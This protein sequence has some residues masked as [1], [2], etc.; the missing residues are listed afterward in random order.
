MTIVVGTF[1]VI[2][3]TIKPV[4]ITF[5]GVW[6]ILSLIR[7]DKRKQIG[8]INSLEKEW[9]D[10]SYKVKLKKAI[11]DLKEEPYLQ[12]MEQ[13]IPANFFNSRD[14]A[15]IWGLVN[16]FRADDFKEAANLLRTIQHQERMEKLQA[17]IIHSTR[18]IN[19]ELKNMR[20]E[21]Q[22]VNVHLKKQEQYLS[23]IASRPAYRT[24]IIMM[25]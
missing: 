24:A 5:F 21:L 25:R 8:K 4:V 9:Q 2:F 10:H 15:G 23:K 16:D 13:V 22:E 1:Y 11:R 14:I 6:L 18:L 17:E 7:F 19:N 20:R 3:L 12:E